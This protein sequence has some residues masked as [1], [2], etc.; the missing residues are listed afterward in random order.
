MRYLNEARD[1]AGAADWPSIPAAIT[2]HRASRAEAEARLDQLARLAGQMD[3]VRADDIRSIIAAK[4]PQIDAGQTPVD[5][6][7]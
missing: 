2:T 4:S 1:A 5:N 7:L 3:Y 6:P